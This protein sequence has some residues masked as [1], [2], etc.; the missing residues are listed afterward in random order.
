[1]KI[2]VIGYSGNVN[3]PPVKYLK[4]ICEELGRKIAL[5][6]HVLITGGTDGIMDLVSKGAMESGG[7]VVGIVPEREN[8]NSY[9]SYEL[10]TGIDS[11]MRSVLMMYNVD[12][13]ISVGGKAGTALELFAAYLMEI[14]IVLLR[15]T[16]GWTDRISNVLIEG[17]YLDERRIV[18]LSN[19]WNVDEAINIAESFR[20]A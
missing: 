12:A 20:R 4:E 11:S 19:A 15:G 14:P 18:E 8:G 9:L 3:E 17:K 10:K 1:M 5:R 16:G 6:K 13:I 7:T 2:G